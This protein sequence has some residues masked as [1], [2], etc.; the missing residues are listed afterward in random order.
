MLQL[1]LTQK[2]IT[3]MEH[4]PIPPILLF[5]KIKS[6]L[7]GRRFKDTEDIQKN[8]MMA[9]KANHDRNSKNVSNNG[10]IVGLSAQLLKGSTSKVTPLSVL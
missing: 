3:E 7:K 10:S 4:H 6:T 1:T 9:L 5:P 2:S 8:V